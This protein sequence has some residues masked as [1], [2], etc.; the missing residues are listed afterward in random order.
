[1][2]DYSDSSKRWCDGEGITLCQTTVPTTVTGVKGDLMEKG[3]I[4][5]A[6]TVVVSAYVQPWSH[7][8][9][10][11]YNAAVSHLSDL[12]DWVEFFIP[13]QRWIA[14]TRRPCYKHVMGCLWLL[15]LSSRHQAI[16]D[17]KFRHRCLVETGLTKPGLLR[18]FWHEIY[19]IRPK[20]TKLGEILPLQRKHRPVLHKSS[21]SPQNQHNCVHHLFRQI[22]RGILCGVLF[23]LLQQ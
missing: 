10:Q 1:M 2:S 4:V 14:Y 12:I 6:S 22:K 5:C 16:C 23:D 21:I 15:P 9:G 18:W 8:F 19:R 17:I 7:G 20:I 3:L 11:P 13:D